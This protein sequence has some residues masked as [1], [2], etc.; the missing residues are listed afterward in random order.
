MEFFV[1]FQK[2]KGLPSLLA[3]GLPRLQ[4]QNRPGVCEVSQDLPV[5]CFVLKIAPVSSPMNSEHADINQS[6]LRTNLV[7][8]YSNYNFQSQ[9]SGP[10]SKYSPPKLKLKRKSVFLAIT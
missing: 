2:E 8:K 6:S 5:Q 4:A 9:I 3:L 1:I 7:R 10:K